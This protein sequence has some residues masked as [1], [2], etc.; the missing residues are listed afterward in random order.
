MDRPRSAGNGDFRLVSAI[1]HARHQHLPRPFG[2][3]QSVTQL[4]LLPGDLICDAFGVPPRSDHRQILRS[5][6]NVMIWGAVG[7]A[8]ALKIAF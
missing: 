5:F 6:F 8:V 3:E 1:R 4:L 7:T 2:E